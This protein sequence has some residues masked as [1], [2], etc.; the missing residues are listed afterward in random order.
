MHEIERKK[1]Y[2]GILNFWYDL[3]GEPYALYDKD[4]LS[5]KQHTTLKLATKRVSAL[6]YKMTTLLQHVH[7]DTLLEMGYPKA[8]LHFIKKSSALAPSVIARL[9]FVADGNTFKVLELNSDTPT[10]IKECFH[11]NGKVCE[12]FSVED[13]NEG[14][15]AVLQRAIEHAITSVT[16]DGYVVFTSHE[17]DVEDRETVLYLQ[18]LCRY[19]SRYVPLHKLQL[20][21]GEGLFDELGQKID[22]LYRQ[23]F[24]IESLLLDKTEAG[25]PLGEMLLQLVCDG[26]LHF[27]NPP[28]AFLLQNKAVQ[29]II[30]GL[31]EEGNTFFT[32]EEHQWIQEYFLPTYLEAD[33]FVRTN[34][35][36]VKK[37]LY[38]REGDTV[39]IYDGAG[40]K[41]LEEKQKTYEEYGFIYQQFASL[42]KIEVNVNGTKKTLHQM[43]GSFVLH[44]KESAIGCRVGGQITN[45]L[46][47]F[48]P[49]GREKSC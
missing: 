41:V 24:P 30:W 43:F 26:T 29:A 10:F 16:T 33:E 40:T 19:P 2:E 1:L 45:N 4:L 25:E 8:S 20:I 37:P 15:E 17:D 3:Y 48:L 46:S 36:Y 28:S 22:V 21:E 6:F 39:E 7:D 34:T 18:Q 13:V 9:D 49:V 38:G 35:K 42:P 5:S 47:Y 14:E 32:E 27:I 11:V 23:T 31:H 44:G 12:A